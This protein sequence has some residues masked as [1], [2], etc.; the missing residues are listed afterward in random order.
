M[1]VNDPPSSPLH[2]QLLVEDSEERLT[3]DQVKVVLEIV[4]Q[5]LTPTSGVADPSARADRE[6]EV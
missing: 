4:N 2:I 1:I 6:A 3:E 5:W